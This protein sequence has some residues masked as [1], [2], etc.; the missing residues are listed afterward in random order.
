ME[1]YGGWSGRGSAGNWEKV[2]DAESPLED[3]RDIDLSDIELDL[4]S[5]R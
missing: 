2:S 4:T 5:N 1:V 3:Q